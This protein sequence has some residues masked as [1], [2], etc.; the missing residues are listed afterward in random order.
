MLKPEEFQELTDWGL[1]LTDIMG[2]GGPDPAAIFN[3][4]DVTA[5]ANQ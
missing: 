2:G 1:G 3:K 4:L 5:T